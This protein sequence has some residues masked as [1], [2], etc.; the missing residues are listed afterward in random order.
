A[1]DASDLPSC[2]AAL[3]ALPPGT[4]LPLAA[5]SLLGEGIDPGSDDW[6]RLD[7][8]HLRADGVRLLLVPLPPGDIDPAEPAAV[9]D[10]LAP[11][12]AQSDHELVAARHHWYL[13]SSRRLDLRTDPPPRTAGT[14]D[15]RQLP[16][17]VDGAAMR[18]LVTEAQMLLHALPMNEA[19]EAGGKLS[20]NALWP[21]GSGPLVPLARSRYS[22]VFSDDPV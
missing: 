18:R 20:I 12:L 16:Q 9:Q 1:I 13:R 22:H 10:A 14:I 4:A 21:W 15:E 8:V 11:L 3:F 19:R 5:L 2:L 7:P 6:L 17:G